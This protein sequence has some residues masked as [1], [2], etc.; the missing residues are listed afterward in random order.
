MQILYCRQTV[1]HNASKTASPLVL[2]GQ[3]I[4]H[5]MLTTED[6]F[7][8]EQHSSLFASVRGFR[9]VSN[10]NR[11]SHVLAILFCKPKTRQK[12]KLKMSCFSKNMMNSTLL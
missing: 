8:A 5:F 12:A 11:F 1:M 3:V 6:I 7:G 10:I 4:R 9:T 2:W